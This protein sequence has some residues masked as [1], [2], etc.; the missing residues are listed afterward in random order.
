[1]EEVDSDMVMIEHDS[2]T[3]M[4]DEQEIH[5]PNLDDYAVSKSVKKEVKDNLL[6]VP[7]SNNIKRIGQYSSMIQKEQFL[8]HSEEVQSPISEP[9]LEN[10]EP[11][12][13]NKPSPAYVLKMT[14]L[15]PASSYAKPSNTEPRKI[16]TVPYKPTVKLPCKV[17]KPVKKL[18]TITNVKVSQKSFNPRDD[19]IAIKHIKEKIYQRSYLKT[20]ENEPIASTPIEKVYVPSIAEKPIV[21]NPIEVDPILELPI[22]KAP[23]KKKPKARR[24]TIAE[25][26]AKV[27]EAKVKK[28]KSP[29]KVV[30]PKVP[31]R[32]VIQRSKLISIMI[33]TKF[34][35]ISNKNF[36][37]FN[38]KQCCCSTD[39]ARKLR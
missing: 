33:K 25:R 16:V 21:E 15:R 38:R 22:L 13:I 18:N 35:H 34:K 2:D 5:Q 8:E 27:V 7:K 29:K 6:K 23:P 1:M 30:E 11:T 28:V 14:K 24:N 20:N 37:F 10:E 17:L 12:I 26:P 4:E 9:E 19:A 36:T 3:E 39:C 32:K 31:K